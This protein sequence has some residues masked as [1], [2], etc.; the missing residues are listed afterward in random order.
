MD[1]ENLQIEIETSSDNAS[2]KIDKLV[3]SL[4]KLKS[5]INENSTLNQLAESLKKISDFSLLYK[6]VLIKKLIHKFKL[7]FT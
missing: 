4:K 1:I 2:S 3:N 7:F 5:A 6:D